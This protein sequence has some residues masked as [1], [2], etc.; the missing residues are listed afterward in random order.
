MITVID[1]VALCKHALLKRN[2]LNKMSI[3]N[4]DF[5]QIREKEK[6]NIPHNRLGKA[7]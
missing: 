1:K 4:L 7:V 5:P 6:L 3:K 2:K